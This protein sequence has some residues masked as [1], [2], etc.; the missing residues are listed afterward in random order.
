MEVQDTWLEAVKVQKV[1]VIIVVKQ[2]ISKKTA[3]KLRVAT[4]VEVETILQETV[5]NKTR[6]LI[7]EKEMIEVKEEVEGIETEA[8][9]TV[10]IETGIE[11][12]VDG[13]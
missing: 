12:I 4:N 7:E 6:D 2:G 3:Q 9:G 10:G 11:K 8:I 1:C 5:T 13:T